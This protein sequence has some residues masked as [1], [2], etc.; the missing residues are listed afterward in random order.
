MG[1]FI[2]LNLDESKEPKKKEVITYDQWKRA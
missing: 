2:E 1:E